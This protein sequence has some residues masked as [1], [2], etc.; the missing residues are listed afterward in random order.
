[1]KKKIL[2]AALILVIAIQA[3]R[4]AKNSSAA[5]TD[6]DITHFV[7]VPDSVMNILQ[8][9]CYDCHSNKTNYKWYHEIM[10]LGWWLDD[11][12]K[13]GKRHLNFSDFSR[14]DKKKIDHKLE[15]IA[16][17]TAEHKM[18]MESYL[19]LHGEAAL[20]EAQIRLLDEWVKT[21]RNKLNH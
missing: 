2:I 19:F 3:F 14:Y 1:M 6:K 12:V 21:E 9:S 13:D 11:H 7:N 15:E 17:E 10:P 16:E 8:V 5:V 4:P 20:S 18:P